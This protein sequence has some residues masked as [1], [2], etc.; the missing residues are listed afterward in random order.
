[1]AAQRRPV[2]AGGGGGRRADTPPPSSKQPCGGR[3]RPRGGR[4]AAA[5]AVAAMGGAA[6]M[7]ARRGSGIGGSARNGQHP[8]MSALAPTSPYAA[9]SQIVMRE[10]PRSPTAGSGAATPMASARMASQPSGLTPG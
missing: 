1:A 2:G 3:V 7:G 5:M 8:L 4:V 10:P 9:G 6:Y